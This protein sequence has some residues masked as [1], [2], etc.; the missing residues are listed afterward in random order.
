V[1][2]LRLDGAEVREDVRVVVFE[3]EQH[4]RARAVPDELGALVEKRGVVL[5]GLDDEERRG[6][7]ARGHA[8]IARDA[9]DQEPR[10]EP[11]VLEDPGEHRGG[12]ALAVGAGH[13]HHPFL[14]QHVLREPL[15]P[16]HV[17]Q[18]AIEHRLDHRLA[19]RERIADHVQVGP[20]AVELLGVVALV[21]VDA[22]LAQLLAHRRVDLRVAP[23]DGV[24][25]LARDLGEPSHEGAGDAE[26]MEV[27]LRIVPA[28][29]GNH[30]MRRR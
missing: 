25:E 4:R 11:R 27:H 30:P 22:Q 18:P 5:V 29:A 24:A 17:R 2:E 15:R 13:R 6:S 28:R 16:G 20:V 26:D 3:V 12:G 19:A 1:V 8:E 9:A 23:G 7:R 21:Q 10:V 14:A